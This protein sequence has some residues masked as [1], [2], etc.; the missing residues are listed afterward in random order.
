MELYRFIQ[1]PKLV[2]PFPVYSQFQPTSSESDELDVFK[3]EEIQARKEGLPYLPVKSGPGQYV[4]VCSQVLSVDDC[5]CQ[6]VTV[7]V[8]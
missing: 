5:Q 6:M 8:S 7:N 1:F 4:T 2:A 3:A